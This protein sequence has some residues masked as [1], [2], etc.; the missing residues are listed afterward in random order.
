MRR[1]PVIHLRG[2]D[3]ALAQAILERLLRARVDIVVPQSSLEYYRERYSVELDFGDCT[4]YGSNERPLEGGHRLFLLGQGP[5]NLL[6]DGESGLDV[7]GLEVVLALP[8]HTGFE[9][10]Y[11]WID[12]LVLV[13]D[14]LPRAK[15]PDWESPLFPEWMRCLK[16]GLQPNAGVSEHWWVS[17]VDVADAMVRILLSNEPFSKRISVS[18]RR[19]WPEKQTLVELSMLY[20]RTMAGRTGQFSVEHLTAAPTPVI[21]LQPLTVSPQLPMSIEENANARPD[22]SPLH[23]LL[24]RIDGDGWRPL[25]PIR[26]ALMH[27]LADYMD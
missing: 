8:G 14:L 9:V 19:S 12:A 22:L 11:D 6:S 5:F 15:D 25:I 27:A 20:N 4:L 24:H 3:C 16:S 13:H 7:D 10:E 17:D 2:V 18:G 21:E 26:T 1:T 23:D